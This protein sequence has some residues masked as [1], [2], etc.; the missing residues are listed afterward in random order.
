M[1]SIKKSCENFEV[2]HNSL[3]DF[4]CKMLLKVLWV[5]LK[6]EN[7]CKK[8][9][10]AM[11]HEFETMFKSNI[12]WHK[13]NKYLWEELTDLILKPRAI[14][15]RTDADGMDFVHLINS[16][17]FTLRTYNM[18]KSYPVKNTR[19]CRI[20]NSTQQQQQQQHHATIFNNTPT[21]KIMT[22]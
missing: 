17:L 19:L 16:L 6:K 14:I 5:I 4:F 11:T 13:A 18:N 7:N 20:N 1:C 8:G 15:L 9:K 10:W 3:Y 22:V 2:I 21:F 12:F